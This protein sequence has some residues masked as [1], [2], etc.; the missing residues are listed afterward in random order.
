MKV[1]IL[2]P[3]LQMQDGTPSTN[4]GDLIIQDAVNREVNRLFPGAEVARY[5]THSPL[6]KAQLGSLSEMEAI[7]VGGTNLLTSR[8][9]PWNRWNEQY[10]RWSN[11][12]SIHLMDAMR[13][14]RAV[15]LGTGWVT[16]QEEPDRFTR[17]M[18]GAALNHNGWH[19]VRDEYSRKRLS[20]AGITNVLN[21]SCVTMWGFADMDMTA[22]PTSKGE[23]A[24]VMLTDYAKN[25]EI[26]SQLIHT[27][28][29]RYK[30]VYAWPQGKEDAP[31]L[32]EV[33]FKGVMLERTLPAL[34]ALLHSGISLDY[35]G[36]RLHGGMRCL[37]NRLRALIIEV[38][39]RA[40]EIAKDTGLPTVPRDDFATINRWIEESP[41]PSIHLPMEE[42]TRW[43]SQFQSVIERS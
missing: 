32:K 43:R 36:T 13:I 20:E 24:L 21:T 42:I 17:W 9:R 34:D 5:A 14:K 41:I 35:V 23:N 4:L 8:F 3:G 19:S 15:L 31:Y 26:D 29:T 39:N 6:T 18:Y 38:D 27:L 40:T 7:L 16:Y 30:E 10:Q 22:F 11:Q 33:G 1:C 25:P 37:Q 2:D 28:Q 12:W